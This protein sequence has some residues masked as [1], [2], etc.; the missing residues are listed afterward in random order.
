MGT[1]KGVTARTAH[2]CENCWRVPSL[3]D[4]MNILPGHRYLLHTAFPGDDGFDAL[5]RPFSVRECASCA[6]ERD[7]YN[8]S[9][10]EICGTYCCSTEP[11]A[12]PFER[13][14]AGYGHDHVCKRCMNDRRE[15]APSVTAPNPS[16]GEGR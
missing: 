11:C 3:R 15:M 13:A 16:G 4:T 9:K 7:D 8:A 10:Y 14:G 1:I 2:P 6:V 12:L 5:E